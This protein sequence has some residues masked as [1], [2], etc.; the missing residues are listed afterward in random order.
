MIRHTKERPD[1][2]AGVA[3]MRGFRVEVV[4]EVGI[5]G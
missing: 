2:L 3:H 5:F 1:E 4:G